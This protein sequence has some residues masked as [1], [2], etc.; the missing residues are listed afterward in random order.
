M[1]I[2]MLLFFLANSLLVFSQENLKILNYNLS[3]GFG[4]NTAELEK[5]MKGQAVDIAAFQGVDMEEEDLK[6]MAKKWKHKNVAIVAGG[7]ANIALTST[8]PIKVTSAEGFLKASVNDMQLYA[9][10][11]NQDSF[12]HRE[13]MIAALAADVEQ[14]IVAEKQVLLLGHI[15]GYAKADSSIYAQR[16]R[17]VPIKD[18]AD[19]AIIRQISSYARPKNY[20]L[21]TK[22]TA[23][24]LLDPVGMMRTGDEV[25][26]TFPS[27]KAG[28]FPQ[29]RTYR[30]DYALIS[31]NLKTSYQKVS[32]LKDDWTK[33]YSE[34]YPILLELKAVVED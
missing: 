31:P 11:V 34:H 18:R 7:N 3:D 24:G 30:V 29:Y 33:Q 6:K 10:Q 19:R 15:E 27:K 26:S 16:F 17:A 14:Q 2:T 22:L 13:A 20:Q 32:V 25:E 5:W 9:V 28:D 12:K 21:M 1:R 4:S 23:T 8:Y